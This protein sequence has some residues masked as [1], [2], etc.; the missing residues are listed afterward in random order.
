MRVEE[1]ADLLI[2]IFQFSI[3]KLPVAAAFDRHEFVRHNRRGKGLMQSR[4]L[5]VGHDGICVSMNT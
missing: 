2:G 5:I 4:R 1:S 3:R